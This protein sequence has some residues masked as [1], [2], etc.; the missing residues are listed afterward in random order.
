MPRDQASDRWE[1]LFKRNCS[2]APR[3][4]ALAYGVLCLMSFSVA[5]AFAWRGLWYVPLFSLLEMSAV[6]LALLHAARHGADYDYI[7]LSDAGLL[8]QQVRAGRSCSTRLDPYWTR[9]GRPRRACD[10]IRL[11]A[12]GV[13]IAVGGFAT[14]ARRRQVALELEQHLARGWSR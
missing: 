2:L 4:W 6:A 9:I 7:A 11:E 3:Q 5:A 1:C 10:L 14:P 12:Q 8:V 13:T